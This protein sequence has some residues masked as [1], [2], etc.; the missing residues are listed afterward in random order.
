MSVEAGEGKSMGE[1]LVLSKEEQ[2]MRVRRRETA[3]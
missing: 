1:L 3:R 2:E